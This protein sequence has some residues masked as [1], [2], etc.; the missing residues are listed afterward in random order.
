[1]RQ[2][3]RA[4]RLICTMLSVLAVWAACGH[5]VAL[6]TTSSVGT[7]KDLRAENYGT[8]STNI[9]SGGFAAGVDGKTFVVLRDGNGSESDDVPCIG[10]V[11]DASQTASV[12]YRA[13]N[14]EDYE[15]NAISWL[16]VTDHGLVFAELHMRRATG[17][18]ATAEIVRTRLDGSGREVLATLDDAR[19][20]I[21]NTGRLWVGNG[22]IFFLDGDVLYA[23]T[24]DGESR[25]VTGGALSEVTFS[26]SQR[27]E[28][29]RI[30]PREVV[31]V[32][33]G[34]VWVTSAD[35]TAA[36]FLPPSGVSRD[37]G[38]RFSL[39][40]LAL[41]SSANLKI[42]SMCYAG[43]QLICCLDERFGDGE[44]E[45]VTGT[46]TSYSEPPN[47]M[48]ASWQDDSKNRF[49]SSVNELGGELFFVTG[50]KEHAGAMALYK[51][52]YGN[53]GKVIA[54]NRLASIADG[55]PISGVCVVDDAIYYKNSKGQL[56]SVDKDGG[57]PHVIAMS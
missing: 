36:G 6:A 24:V 46:W 21:G 17:T 38:R 27:R 49:V 8:S 35:R 15:N 44:L 51:S 47:L 50:D 5:A 57:S 19:A 32:E 3:R 7:E 41:P 28:V 16:H 39:Q 1:M 22:L 48:Y 37:Y 34:Q 11:S 30:D 31:M 9:A 25:T 4:M 54:N 56:C 26:G 14:T 10:V 18:A 23:Q 53:G 33:H 13:H 42:V 40:D 52:T 29:A 2:Q 43:G 55:A 12:I 45:A 20:R